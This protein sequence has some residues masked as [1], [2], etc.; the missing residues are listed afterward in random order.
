M[1]W[2]YWDCLSPK[3]LPSNEDMGFELVDHA[4]P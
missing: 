4:C 3:H 2:E 1:T